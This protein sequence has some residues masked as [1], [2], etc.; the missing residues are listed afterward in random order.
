M[1]TATSDLDPVGPF[2]Q[3]LYLESS[4]QNRNSF[5]YSISSELRC[6]TLKH[7]EVLRYLRYTLI[8]PRCM[9]SNMGKPNVKARVV[10]IVYTTNEKR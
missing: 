6:Q 7:Y 4:S 10:G 9:H 5:G 1:D 3:G 2:D 8:H